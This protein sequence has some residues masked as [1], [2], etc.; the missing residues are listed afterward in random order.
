M[1]KRRSPMPVELRDLLL[2][3][4]CRG[5]AAG[6][7]HDL[8]LCPGPELLLIAVLDL[9]GQTRSALLDSVGLGHWRVSKSLQSTQEAGLLTRQ[10]TE[11]DR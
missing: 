3:W 7:L 1:A 10:P 8:G 6:L 2:A 9:D 5:F 11:L 4:A